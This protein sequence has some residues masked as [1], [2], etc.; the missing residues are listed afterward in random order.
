MQP[1]LPVLSDSYA[2][3]MATERLIAQLMA[4]LDEDPDSSAIQVLHQL[5]D[6]STI[7]DDAR[8]LSITDAAAL[9]GLSTHTLRYY[10]DQGLV[11]PQRTSSGYRTYS[12][13]DLR[14]LLFLTRMRVSGMTM[15]DLR[16]Y[17]ALVEQG[18]ETIPERRGIMLAQ[19]ERIARQIRELNL[20]LETTEYKLRTYGTGDPGPSRM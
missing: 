15:T 3:P 2:R 11:H 6:D 5:L 18:E 4:Q 12:A 19:R 16:R 13:F 14:R 10:E 17:I 7:E 9:L 1:P 8:P 20:A